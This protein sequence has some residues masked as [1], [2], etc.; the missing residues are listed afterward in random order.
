V[1]YLEPRVGGR[2]YERF[3]SKSGAEK[4]IDTGRVTVWE[5][6]VKLAFEWRAVNFAPDE[7]TEVVVEFVE[8]PSGTLVTVVHR[9]WSRIRADHPV[10][11]GEEVAAFIRSMGRW[12]GDLMTSLRERV[13]PGREGGP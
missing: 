13:S 10:R 7:K 8:K 5:P 1:L 9:G 11:H 4:V 2:L 6:P 3:E 12:W